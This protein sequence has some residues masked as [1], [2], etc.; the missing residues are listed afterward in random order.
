MVS[1]IVKKN[2]MVDSFAAAGKYDYV[3]C[4]TYVAGQRSTC[5][6]W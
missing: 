6:A 3:W 1:A 5:N 2:F 4:H